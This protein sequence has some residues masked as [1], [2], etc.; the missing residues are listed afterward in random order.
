MMM[1]H[2][3]RAA[4]ILGLIFLPTAAFAVTDVFD[5]ELFI[6]SLLG[7]L[8]YFF[9]VLAIVA[10]FYGLVKFISNAEDSAERETGKSIMV[11][12]IIALT[13]LFSLWGIVRFILVDTLNINAAPIDYI[14]KNGAVV[15]P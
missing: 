9:W 11:W 8:G 14:D 1:K 4:G 15:S 6:I 13:V 10:F 3:L 12:G 7:K 2:S 5:L